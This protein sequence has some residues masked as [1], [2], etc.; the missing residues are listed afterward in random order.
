M[1]R[2]LLA[3]RREPRLP[4]RPPAP[5]G[6]TSHARSL[7]HASALV[8][9]RD[10]YGAG[11][12]GR[13]DDAVGVPQVVGHA[14]VLQVDGA[15]A[16]HVLH[17]RPAGEYPMGAYWKARLNGE[18]SRTKLGLFPSLFSLIN[19]W[20]WEYSFFSFLLLSF[21]T[22]VYWSDNL[23]SDVYQVLLVISL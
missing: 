17:I 12:H 4:P 22:T 13:A 6:Q 8:L 21:V 9:A 14:Q 15:R 16:A 10:R 11:R 20:L 18:L 19:D 2:R 5:I 3:E 23:L 7:P 1:Q